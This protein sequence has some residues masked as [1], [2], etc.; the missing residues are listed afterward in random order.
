MNAGQK[1]AAFAVALLAVGAI[2]AGIGAAVGPIDTGSETDHA[3]EGH[4]SDVD[5]ADTSASD[6][7]HAGHGDEPGAEGAGSDGAATS[8]TQDG[9]R[10]VLEEPDGTTLRFV[11]VDPEGAPVVDTEIV[12]DEALHLVIVG[13]DL[14]GYHHVHPEVDAAGTWQVD[15]PGMTP[16]SY[17][18]VADL[19]PTDGPALALAG[20]LTVPG[21]VE[22]IGAVDVPPIASTAEVDGLTVAVQGTPRVGDAELTFAVTRDGAPVTLEPY[23]G[24]R[25]HLV[26]FRTSDLAYSHVHPHDGDEGPVAFTASF[27]SAGTYRL[28]LDL[29]VDGE[30]RTAAFTVEVP[31][32]ESEPSAPAAPTTSAPETSAP[33]TDHEHEGST[34]HEHG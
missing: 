3:D 34:D 23:L 24:A 31:E 4:G 5:H 20:D 25:G 13:R 14:R 7:A 27:P 12:H 30:V 11:V 32:P 2:G 19:T 28:F 6:D 8:A 10:L 26:A 1:V 29:K 9:Y 15:V 33:T 16:G 22:A 21:P 18:A 17:R